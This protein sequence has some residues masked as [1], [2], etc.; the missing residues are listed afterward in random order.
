MDNGFFA[1]CSNTFAVIRSQTGEILS[2]VGSS[3][4]SCNNTHSLKSITFPTVVSFW[5]FKLIFT[6]K[7]DPITD[8]IEPMT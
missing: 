2:Q 5:S 3:V 8:R 4:I 1:Q 7:C 6:T